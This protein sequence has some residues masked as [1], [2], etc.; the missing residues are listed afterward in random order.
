MKGTH[1]PAEVTTGPT[2]KASDFGNLF[3]VLFVEVAIVLRPLLQ[4][5][6]D[7]LKQ[8]TIPA[9]QFPVQ[10]VSSE[11]LVLSSRMLS[12]AILS[13]FAA[14]DPQWTACLY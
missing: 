7:L 14:Q 13:V 5:G 3:D 10:C 8:Q 2:A 4:L 9:D 12:D 6:D 11:W 1:F